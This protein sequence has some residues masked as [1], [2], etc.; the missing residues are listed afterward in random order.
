MGN[1]EKVETG[2]QEEK[3]HGTLIVG[4]HYMHAKT[5][6]IINTWEFL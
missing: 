3:N 2:T 5:N 1:L 6:N 4:Q